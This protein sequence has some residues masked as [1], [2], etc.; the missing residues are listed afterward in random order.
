M[1]GGSRPLAAQ[2]E[3]G[4]QLFNRASRCDSHRR[5]SRSASP[6]EPDALAVRSGFPSWRR[7][8]VPAES[9]EQIDD[10][11]RT[12]GLRVERAAI[13]SFL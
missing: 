4:D 6:G 12:I 3:G 10:G 8:L 1:S 13:R 9:I 2:S 11:S 7:W 5:P